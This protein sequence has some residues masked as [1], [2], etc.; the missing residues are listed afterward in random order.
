M[1]YESDAIAACV[2]GGVSFV[3]GIGKI[4]GIIIGV[5]MLRLIFVGP[6]HDS[7]ASG[8][9]LS[10]Q[11]RHHSVCLRAGY[12]EVPGQEMSPFSHEDQISQLVCMEMI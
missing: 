6:D 12:A 5:L 9:D 1:N 3:G 10:G 8:P 2:I 4:R 11:R 7:S